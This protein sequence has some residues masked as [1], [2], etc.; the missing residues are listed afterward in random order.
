MMQAT[1]SLLLTS[2]PTKSVLF[3]DFTSSL[4]EF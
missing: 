4:D 3:N 2:M 1:L